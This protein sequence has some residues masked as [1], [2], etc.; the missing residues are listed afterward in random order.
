MLDAVALPTTTVLQANPTAESGWL[1]AKQ[2][3]L[4]RSDRAVT[5]TVDPAAAGWARIGWSSAESASE[6]SLPA[7]SSD[8]RWQVY[9]GGYSVRSEPRC[10]PLTVHVG[11][12]SAQVKIGVGVSC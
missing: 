6:F 4:V 9:A 10:L 3:L 12:R 8:G 2:G 5:I 7:C 1:F 11:E